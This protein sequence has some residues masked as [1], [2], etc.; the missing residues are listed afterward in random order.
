MRMR[1]LQKGDGGVNGDDGA[2]DTRF[3]LMQCGAQRKSKPFS[4]LTRGGE[5]VD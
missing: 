3:D 2:G 5:Y 1:A 4:V